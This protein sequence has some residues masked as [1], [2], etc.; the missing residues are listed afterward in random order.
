MEKAR[1][2]CKVSPP[3]R[4]ISAIGQATGQG[5]FFSRS[6][7]R[8]KL[9]FPHCSGGLIATI[10]ASQ[11]NRPTGDGIPLLRLACSPIPDCRGDESAG[12]HT[13]QAQPYSVTG[14]ENTRKDETAPCHISPPGHDSAVCLECAGSQSSGGNSAWCRLRVPRCTCSTGR[15]AMPERQLAD[16]RRHGWWP[17]DG[18]GQARKQ[19]QT[20]GCRLMLIERACRRGVP[21]E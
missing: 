3:P 19:N 21:P 14:P 15:A 13:R 12:D 16:G 2:E 11:Q 1:D 20:L 7:P 10:P 4:Q 5:L 6:A 18:G 8:Q 9:R 17:D